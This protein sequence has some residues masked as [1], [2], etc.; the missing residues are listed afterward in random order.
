MKK[1]ILLFVF[2]GLTAAAKAQST[3]FGLGLIVGDPTGISF[4]YW[5]TG[6]RAIDGA[7]AWGVTHG[8]Y[9]HLHSD[10]LFHKADLISVSK[11]QF[12]L[13]YGPG[14]RLRSWSGDE[15]WHGGEWHDNDG[16]HLDLGVRFPVGLTYL[17]DGAPVDAFIE[18][19]P[20]LDLVPA[21]GFDIDAGIG[22]RYWF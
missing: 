7:L 16:T 19:V 8:G 13:H 3:G 9:F 18:L 10:Y 6:D 5:L 11:G 14:I 2:V 4:K 22:A 20:T 12:L 17:F 1:S 21:T 15:Y